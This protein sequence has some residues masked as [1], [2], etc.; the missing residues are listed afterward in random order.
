VGDPHE[1]A[2]HVV[3]VEDDLLMVHQCFRLPGL[4]GPG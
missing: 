2:A 1:R 4:T 3:L